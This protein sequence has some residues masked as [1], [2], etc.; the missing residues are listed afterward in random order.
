MYKFRYY[1]ENA[2]KGLKIKGITPQ[3]CSLP[4]PAKSLKKFKAVNDN[5]YFAV[6]TLA[7]E[8][9]IHV[10]KGEIV[11]INGFPFYKKA[12]CIGDM[13]HTEKGYRIKSFILQFER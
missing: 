9:K 13:M 3:G 2:L 10:K 5:D 1:D 11:E 7:K 12:V 4:E 6:S 8:P